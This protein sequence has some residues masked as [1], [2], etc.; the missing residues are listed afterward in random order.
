MKNS[1]PR[2][3]E[4][5]A[6]ATATGNTNTSTTGDTNG[7]NDETLQMYAQVLD[8]M[9]EGV[10]LSDE[11]GILRYTNPAE[12]HMFGY[13]RGELIGKHVSV[14]NTY[15]PEENLRIVHEVIEHLQKKGSWSGE[16]SNCKKDGTPFTTF[17]RITAIEVSGRKYWVCVQEDI[18]ERKRAEE[19][20][21][22]RRQEA[23]AA[24]RD[25]YNLFM[26]AP[27]IIAVV[28]GPEHVFQLAN[29]TYLQLV[30]KKAEDLIGKTVREALPG[31]VEQGYLQLLDEVYKSAQPF[32]GNE[33]VS[34]LDRNSDGTLEDVYL[35]FIYQPIK[36]SE[37]RV[38][39]IF[40]HAVD[41]T[42]QVL[43]R[44]RAEE[45][46]K[47]LQAVFQS[48][49]DGVAVFDTQGNLIMMNEALAEINGYK[50]A[51]EMQ[52][53]LT[54]FAQV[55]RLTYP[56]GTICH[57][58]DWPISRV[59]KGE[60][61]TR[62]ELRGKRLD[63]G[64]EWFFNFSGAPVYDDNGRL[65][66][67]VVVTRDITEEKRSQDALQESEA[68]LRFVA[69]S[70]PQKVFTAK[71]DGDVDYFNP[72][73][74]EYTGLSFEQIR[75]W[76]W[77]QF[78]HPDDVEENVRLWQ[79]STATGEPFQFE[80]RFRRAD[81]MYR[82]HLSRAVP[83]RDDKGNILMWV[84]SNTDVDD[85][86]RLHHEA[87][88]A[89]HARD[90][91]LSV[92]SHELKTP[93]TSIKGYAQLLGREVEQADLLGN[94]RVTRSL[95]AITSQAD[96]LTELVNDMLDI[97]RI[98]R[99][100][101]H[102]NLERIDLVGLV[103]EVVAQVQVLSD[104]HPITVRTAIGT[105]GA[106]QV[107]GLED[108]MNGVDAE[109]P[110]V[111]VIADGERLG[112][113][114]TNLLENAI[115][116][117]PRGGPIEVRVVVFQEEDWVT[118]AV[119]DWG[120]GIS[121]DQLEHIFEPFYRAPNASVRNYGGLGLGLYISRE[122]VMRHGGQLWVESPVESG[123]EGAGGEKGQKGQ[124][125]DGEGSIF[126]FALPLPASTVSLQQTKLI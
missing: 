5:N 90:D 33:M 102:L 72:Q 97:S 6:D 89:V 21:K 27:A 3:T 74:T 101:F 57:V 75:D 78:I 86:K 82:W 65:M 113:V 17:A 126:S 105:R 36:D 121:S 58:D 68:R 24:R 10:S 98:E 95:K 25:L 48:V 81:G 91:F 111:T 59:L 106:S 109:T 62:M 29:S 71:P 108:G 61:F 39:G 46:E 104:K 100:Q 96:R 2:A 12:D 31:L 99:G 79:H 83:M 70:M 47:R 77:T 19:E 40:G 88:E 13:E 80:H 67:A 1:S 18:T 28:Q 44:R 52:K 8:S 66:L 92:A 53:N 123:K 125:T 9:V 117:S 32:V 15:P 45:S 26:Q 110:R 64:Q 23:E 114:L 54:G 120:I 14:Q 42:A 103:R 73:W 119:R 93:I 122:I 37:G 43:A 55:Y 76:G 49:A 87:E 112:Q 116:Y 4:P 11:E 16:F 94:I 7:S 22:A 51:D 30:G 60:A 69:E 20:L 84:G 38:Q 34:K 85:L 41:V 50:S 63:S 35:N 115:K 124:H 118:V 107:D 56:D